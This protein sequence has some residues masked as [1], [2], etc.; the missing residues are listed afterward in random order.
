[1]LN[2]LLKLFSETA[3]PTIVSRYEGKKRSIKESYSRNNFNV[4]KLNNVD[5]FFLL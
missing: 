4:G 1:M 5:N 3:F 2:I